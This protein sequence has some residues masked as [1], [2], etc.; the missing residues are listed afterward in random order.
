MSEEIDQS[1][2]QKYSNKSNSLLV[3]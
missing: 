3:Y 2:R 1:F